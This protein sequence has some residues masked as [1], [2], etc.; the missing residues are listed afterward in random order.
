MDTTHHVLD[1]V[2]INVT[3]LARAREF[4]GQAFGWRFNDYGPEYALL[5]VTACV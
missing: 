2:E 4:Y 5:R 3:D 1:Y